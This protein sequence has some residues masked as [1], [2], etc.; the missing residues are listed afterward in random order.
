MYAALHTQAILS[1]KALTDND[2]N[3]TVCI[4]TP[5]ILSQ[6]QAP[7]IVLLQLNTAMSNP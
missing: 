3:V 7:L 1:R 2:A 4:Q 6:P 5:A